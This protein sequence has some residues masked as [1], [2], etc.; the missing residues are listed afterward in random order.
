[1]DTRTLER[2]VMPALS[3][4][5][6]ALID[7]K[8]FATVATLQPDGRPQLS[9]VWVTR[10]GDDLIFCT[11]AGRQKHRNM[12]RDPRVTALIYPADDP[13][14]Y[15]EIRG[16]ATLTTEGGAEL[17]DTLSVKYTG[18]PYGHDKPGDVRVVVRVSPERVFE[19]P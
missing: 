7:D 3:G 18:E 8:S 9:L 17:I 14:A 16:T 1:V 13:Y 5:A 11:V 6:R 10:E 2:I 12:L 4:K 19:R 15:L